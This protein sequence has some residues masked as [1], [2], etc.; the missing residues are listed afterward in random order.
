MKCDSTNRAPRRA[1]GSGRRRG[2]AAGFTLVELLVAVAVAS[3]FLGGTYAA[4]N[5]ILQAHARVA[6][7]SEAL[8]NARTAITTISD[9]FK[10]V[11]RLGSD[12]LL[13]GIDQTLPYG[14]AIDND[15]DGVADSKTLDGQPNTSGTTFIDLHARIGSL[16]ERP[17]RVG[18][19][20]EGDGN[21][22]VDVKFGRDAI[23]LRIFPRV[24]TPDLTLKTVTYNV[25]TYDGQPNVLVR[26]TRIERTSGEP[27]VG[28]APLAFEV[29]GF[30][31][32]YWNP[33]AP[34]EQQYWVT[35]WDSSQS[36]GFDPPR[37]PL[38][39]SIF[40]RLT[41]NVDARP[42]ASILP[43]AP[44]D[45][46]IMESILNIEQTIGDALYPRTTL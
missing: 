2:V 37:L 21:V 8:R 29:L 13:L 17:L 9:E 10:A 43:G 16:H 22:D 25:E 36:A 4:F 32:L 35:R 34:P 44:V 18:Q 3:A 33:N 6:A 1:I 12:F 11:N 20:D 28:I 31:L 45:T 5:R 15:G 19:P 38:P 41:M 27:L 7:R 46:V 24:P 40:V 14:D 30:D 23:V 42:H 26:R 39:A